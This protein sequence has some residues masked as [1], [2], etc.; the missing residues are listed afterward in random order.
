MEIKEDRYY[1]RT[2]EWV[3]VDGTRLIVGISDHAQ[4]TLG[5]IS[6]VDLPTCA[7][8]VIAGEECAVL[9]SLK[10]AS[11]LFAPF[12]GTIETI[13]IDVERQPDLI[14]RSPYDNGWIWT[15]GSFT[16]DI[17][18]TW[19]TAEQYRLFLNER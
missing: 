2:H 14:N 9:E 10:A 13:N 5:E 17:P 3:R 7:L 11:S 16:G 19:M 8:S 6:Y 1:L 15:M 4:D 18:D 12:S